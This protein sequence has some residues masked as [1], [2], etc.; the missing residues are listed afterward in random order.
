MT[1]Q[2]RQNN[3]DRFNGFGTLYDQSR[4]QAPEE[5]AKISTMYLGRAPEY[6]AD[7]GCGT[8]LS[9]MIWLKHAERVIG[10]EPNDDMRGVALS[11]LRETG[12]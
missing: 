11:R 4:P 9:T 7:V 8:G 12:A 2:I 5:V 10:I 3:V 1:G 6:V